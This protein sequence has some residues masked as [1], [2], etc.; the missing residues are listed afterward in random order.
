MRDVYIVECVRTPVGRARN[1]C[2]NDIHPVDLLAMVLEEVV[3]R[4]G[5]EK[6]EVDD[7]IGGVVTP[8]KEQGGN[9]PRLAVLKAGVRCCCWMMA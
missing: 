4:A 7:V 9:L 6:G 5:V 2:F 8:V 1:G 3:K